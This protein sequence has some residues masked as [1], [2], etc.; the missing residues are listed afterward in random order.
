M[1]TPT[2]HS[3]EVAEGNQYHASI[4]LVLNYGG[5]LA[6]TVNSMGVYPVDRRFTYHYWHPCT[7]WFGK[8]YFPVDGTVVIPAGMVDEIFRLEPP[9]VATPVELT[10]LKVPGRRSIKPG[11]FVYVQPRQMKGTRR[12]GGVVETIY[13]DHQIRVTTGTTTVQVDAQWVHATNDHQNRKAVA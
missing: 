7:G 5:S 10:R 9:E 4:R 12:Y 8:G 1:I 13:S 2:V 3:Y 6:T 11:Q